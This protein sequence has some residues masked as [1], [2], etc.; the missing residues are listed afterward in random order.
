MRMYR[1]CPA[2]FL[3]AAVS[4]ALLI[5]TS[6]TMAQRRIQAVKGKQYRLSKQ[7]GPWMIMVANFKDVPKTRLEIEDGR[8][9]RVT[10]ERYR[11]GLSAQ[12]AADKLVFELRRK[13]IPAYTFSQ[14]DVPDE[15]NTIDRFGRQRTA[16]ILAQKGRVCVLAGNYPATDDKI[17]QRTLKHV[18][19]KFKSKQFSSTEKNTKK[20]TEIASGVLD[21]LI[22]GGVIHRTRGK[23]NALSGAFLTINPLLTPEEA[24][25][26]KRDPLLL[27]L[28]AGGKFN[29]L[30]NPGRFTLVVA[31]SYIKSNVTK[32]DNQFR[33]AL[34]A[35][36][37]TDH[38]DD[39][40]NTA[41]QLTRTLREG[42]VPFR[43]SSELGLTQRNFEAYVFHDRY[44][45]IV[46]IG[47]FASVN[48]SEIPKLKKIFGSKVR[49]NPNTGKEVLVAEV[50][51]LPDP[52]NNGRSLRSWIFDPNPRLIEVPALRR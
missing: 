31:T 43:H 28:N 51:T 33:N 25:K 22:N 36:Q 44:G 27:K 30:D 18:K 32:G 8:A 5:P 50:M 3:L 23:P 1:K 41:W 49:K 35:F 15:V 40:A 29:L 20:R 2:V 9:I 45:S 26:R 47:S 24:A 19:T 6:P 16:T 10:N 21:Q 7:H 12:E 11:D 46:T 38:L 14:A 4:L 39:T 42:N 13:G 52:K 48:D 34:N 17:A 37:L